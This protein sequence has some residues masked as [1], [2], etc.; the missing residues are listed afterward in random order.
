MSG[1]QF[2]GA[3]SLHGLWT[4]SAAA[5]LVGLGLRWSVRPQ[6]RHALALAGLLAA[7]VVA[8]LAVGVRIDAPLAAGRAGHGG[9]AFSLGPALPWVGALWSAGAAWG[10]LG[11]AV[12]A[13]RLRR[14]RRSATPLPPALARRLLAPAR[15]RTGHA[16]PLP[17]ATSAEVTVPTVIGWRRPICLLPATLR[18]EA[19]LQWLLVHELAHVRRGDVAWAWLVALVEVA[20]FYHPAARWLARHVH[21]EREC[22]CDA[23]ATQQPDALG[24]YVRALAGLAATAGKPPA[25]CASA[26][27][28]IVSRIQRMIE[29]NHIPAAPARAACLAL[30]AA[31]LAGAGLV[32][33]C[34]DEPTSPRAVEVAGPA[35]F[36]D[37]EG[38]ATHLPAGALQWQD[39]DGPGQPALFVDDQG[40]AIPVPAE[41][42]PWQEK[43]KTKDAPA[44]L[45]VDGDGNT[46]PVPAGALQWKDKDGNAVPDGG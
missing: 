8:A 6:R 25:L 12:A 42:L 16:G 14:L 15:A 17:L 23:V 18:D 39:K 40:N 35:K 34:D 3:A 19:E 33:A 46:T 32:A 38:K 22:C 30:L 45:F 41:A 44:A 13:R 1:L 26:G 31:S 43:D 24:P 37:H 20:L 9:P 7:P 36:V 5:A 28:M 11:L 10:L 27:G 2:L 21:H 4:A 29:A